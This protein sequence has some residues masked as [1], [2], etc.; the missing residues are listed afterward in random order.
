MKN[1][2]LEPRLLYLASLSFKM[3]GDVKSSSNK[4]TNKQ[5]KKTKRG[6]LHQDSTARDVKR[7]ALRE[8]VGGGGT[9]VQREK[10]Q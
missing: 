3:E 6:H 10:W 8:E 4:Q 2:D 5:T 9:Q 1:K 7:T